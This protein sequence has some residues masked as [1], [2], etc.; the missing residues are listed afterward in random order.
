MHICVLAGRV[1]RFAGSHVYNRELIRRFAARG[2]RVTVVCFAADQET[3]SCSEVHAISPPPAR[4][5]PVVWRLNSALDAFLVA[6][7]FAKL[8][9][10]EPEIVFAA[11]HLF[12][13][14]FRKRFK[15][16]PL[17][18]FPMSP[19]VSHELKNQLRDRWQFLVSNY[20]YRTIQQWA[21]THADATV[22]F[23]QANCRI[24]EASYPTVRPRFRINPVGVDVPPDRVPP[25]PHSQIRLLSVGRLT[26]WKGLDLTLSILA[27]LKDFAWRFDIVGDGECRRDLEAKVESLGLAD[28]VVFHGF[29]DQL[30]SWYREAHLFLF[31]SRCESLGLV[32]LDAMAYGVP[33]LGIR[34]D[35]HVYV[36][37][38]D[39]IIQH[40]QTGLLAVDENDYATLLR[41]ALLSPQLLSSLG[42][43]AR[44]RVIAEN[45]WSA[46]IRRYEELFT[47]IRRPPA[48]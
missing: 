37:A 41:E 23:T 44:Q 12:I 43:A 40:R 27:E 30:D 14:P 2:H 26:P 47:A 38:N 36:N 19:L 28:R 46:H 8:E 35:G 7:R 34:S 5:A 24:L 18:Y 45:T 33:C 20:V 1:D 39:E 4:T 13:R 48:A 17:V 31:P 10:P 25:P 16:T 32:A 21:L 6:A 3:R 15:T 22:R 11:E 9:V 29:C 42:A